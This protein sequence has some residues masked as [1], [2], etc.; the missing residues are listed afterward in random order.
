MV[1][2]R[3]G[4]RQCGATDGFGPDARGQ[5]RGIVKIIGVHLDHV[6]AGGTQS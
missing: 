5:L 2:I 4:S 1:V 6:P 3:D